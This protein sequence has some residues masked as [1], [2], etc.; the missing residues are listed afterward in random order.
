MGGDTDRWVTGD[1]LGRLIPADPEALRRG[2]PNFL[3]DAFR[4]SGVLGADNAVRS[5]TGFRQIAGGST[6]R[7]V[8]LSVEY[9]KASPGLHTELF[10]K[11]SR[12]FGDSTRDRG[13]TQMES[14]VRFASLSR[15]PGF[16]IAVPDVLFGDYHRPTATGVLITERIRFGTNGIE[17]QYHK[18][19]DYEMPEPVA[20]YRALLTTVA[21]LAGTHRSGRLPAHLTAGF[22]ADMQAATVGERAPMRMDKLDRQLTQLAEFAETHTA[23]LPPNVDSAFLSRL[24]D[25]APRLAQHEEFI[26]RHLAAD[27]DYVALCHWNANVDNAWF[28][29]DT[30]DV[31]RCGLMDWGCVSQMNMGMAIWGAMSGAETDLWDCHFDELLAAFV[32]GVRGCGGPDLDPARLARHTLLYAASM[33]V[34]W[35]LDVPALIRRRFGDAAPISRKDPHIKDD[36]SVRAPLQMLSNVLSLWERHRVADL[37]EEALAESAIEGAERLRV[38]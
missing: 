24:R 21:R 9:D 13:K 32:A 20:H 4:M 10:A 37:L 5:I 27:D 34:A 33:G 22:A 3:T 6:G 12:D 30:D 36:E 11:F 17:R 14:E 38:G 31:L 25:E 15:A 35:L 19:L 18:C 29:R 7:K 16:P 28:W 23:L 2:G 8:A 1:Q 26:V